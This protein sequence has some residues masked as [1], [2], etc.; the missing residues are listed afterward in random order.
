MRYTLWRW[1]MRCTLWWHSISLIFYNT[2]LQTAI[3]D[4]VIDHIVYAALCII[5]SI[6][7]KGSESICLLES[8]ILQ[9]IYNTSWKKMLHFVDKSI[10]TTFIYNQLC[11]RSYNYIYDNYI[12]LIKES[13]IFVSENSCLCNVQF[14]FCVML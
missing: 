14:R 3:K 8:V 11:V 12:N 10:T 13:A 9:L 7:G 1:S 6:R 2:L 4:P 5:P